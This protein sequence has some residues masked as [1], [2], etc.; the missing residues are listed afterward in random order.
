[1]LRQKLANDKQA[2]KDL[3]PSLRDRSRLEYLKKREE[4]QLI[5]LEK[6]ILDEE[7]LFKDEKLTRKEIQ[8]LDKKKMMLRLAKER[9]SM[10][11]NKEDAY[12]MPEDYITEKGKLD[13]KKKDAV[14]FARYQEN[15][16]NE[17]LVTDQDEWEKRQ[18]QYTKG[19]IKESKDETEFDYV[20]DEKQRVDFVLHNAGTDHLIRRD[21]LPQISEKEKKGF[22]ECL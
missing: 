14:L 12:Q 17:A 7:S 20:F 8:E 21:D 4:E 10:D 3:M 1:M 19:L 5:L 16:T 9:L 18:S 13:K 22:F 15:P 11:A 2:R 6:E